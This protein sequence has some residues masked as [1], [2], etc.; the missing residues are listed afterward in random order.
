MEIAAHDLKL[1]LER[2]CAAMKQAAPE[3]NELDGRIGD[4]DLG[5]TLEK[6]ATHVEQAL[7]AA[8]DSLAGIFKGFAAACSKAYAS[9]FG[10]M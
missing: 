2:W 3:L 7:P 4:G 8:D 6:C 9:S 5:A 1:A 10:K